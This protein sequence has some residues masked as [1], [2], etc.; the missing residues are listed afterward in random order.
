MLAEA[1]R[2]TTLRATS[3][4]RGLRCSLTAIFDVIEDHADFGLAMIATFAATLLDG[5][6]GLEA[7]A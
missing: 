7:A 5:S 2:E 4:G 1:P 3:A 6:L